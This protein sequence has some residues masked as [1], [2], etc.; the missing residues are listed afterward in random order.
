[1]TAVLAWSAAT[2]PRTVCII[3]LDNTA[4]RRVAA[5]LG[6]G[7]LAQTG[8]KDTPVIVFERRR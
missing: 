3:D 4:S 1:M 6:Y 8:Y 7:E 2:H 5:K